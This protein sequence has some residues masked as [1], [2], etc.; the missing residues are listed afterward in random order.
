MTT[1]SQVEEMKIIDDD[2]GLSFQRLKDQLVNRFFQGQ[3]LFF[4]EASMKS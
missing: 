3:G 2:G 4:A 1:G